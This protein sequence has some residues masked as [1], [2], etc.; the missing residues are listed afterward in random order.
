MPTISTP[1]REDG[2]SI[3]DEEPDCNDDDD[4][5][6]PGAIEI[7]D[8]FGDDE[9]CDG[10][11]NEPGADGSV[12]YYLDADGDGYGTADTAGLFVRCR[13]AIPATMMT[14]MIHVAW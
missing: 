11:V 7:C 12:T 6:F 9:D 4:L 1:F 13:K 3:C 14:V 2:S 8:I 10:L 5:I